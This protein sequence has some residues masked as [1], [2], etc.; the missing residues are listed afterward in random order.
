[1]DEAMADDVSTDSTRDLPDTMDQLSLR[2]RD[3]QIGANGF[4]RAMTSAF[5]TSVSG[6]KQFDDVLKSLTLRLSDL[7]LKM[8]LAPVTRGLAGGINQLFQGMFGGGGNGAS[9]AAAMGA[10]KPFAAGGV[11][12]TPT[13]FPLTAGGVGL[14]GEAGP[15][16]IVPLARGTDGRLGV[17]MNGGGAPP[18]V[19]INIATPDADSFRRSETYLTGQIARAVARGQ[20]SL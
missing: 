20:R 2:T 4:A 9:L 7:S 6:G 18:N 16:A 11:I 17:A 1:M 14:A 3:L 19:T 15:E 8:A 13:Y 5:A 10:I 12:G